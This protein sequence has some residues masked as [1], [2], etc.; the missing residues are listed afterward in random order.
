VS[1]DDAMRY[2]DVNASEFLDKESTQTL[3]NEINNKAEGAIDSTKLRSLKGAIRRS[4]C[5]GAARFLQLPLEQL[6]FMNLPFYE[7][8][9][10]KKNEP[11]EK[12]IN[13][14]VALIRELQPHQIFAAGDLADPHGTHRVCLDILF[15]AL[16]LLKDEDF[17]K[18]CWV[19]LYRGAWQEWDIHEIEMAIPLSPDQVNQKRNAILFHQSQMDRAMYQGEDKRAFWLRAQERN[20]NTALLFNSLGMAEYDSMEAFRRYHF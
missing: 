18:D 9:T 19:W 20:R 4:E 10:V 17:M 2:L 15:E 8:G 7:T 5:L 3:Q 14:T 11:T 12:D 6:H 1:D 13:Q 16:A